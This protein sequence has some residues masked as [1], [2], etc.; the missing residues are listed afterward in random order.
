M[1]FWKISYDYL[2]KIAKFNFERCN[3][4]GQILYLFIKDYSFE[5]RKSQ[6]H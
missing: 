1:F 3:L 2:T 5:S 4:T 6:S